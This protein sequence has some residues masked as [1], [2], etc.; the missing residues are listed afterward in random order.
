M[1]I[2]EDL[3]V[4]DQGTLN[5]L[6]SPTAVEARY[7][8][9]PSQAVRPLGKTTDILFL[10]MAIRSKCS[11]KIVTWVQV[12]Q[13]ADTMMSGCPCGQIRQGLGTA[14]LPEMM[15]FIG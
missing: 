10:R 5:L 7:Y 13:T 3:T 2:S 15:Y 14:M 9:S 12:L 11:K 1:Y 8:N 4:L 6:F